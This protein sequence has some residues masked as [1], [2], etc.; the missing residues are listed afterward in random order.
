VD[1]QPANPFVLRAADGRVIPLGAV[2]HIGRHRTCRIHLPDPRVSRH[3]A[4]L[5]FED[6]MLFVR[7]EGSRNGLS[8]NGRRIAANTSVRLYPG[9]VLAIA[10]AAFIVAQAGSEPAPD[11]EAAAGRE[12]AAPTGQLPGPAR[13][14]APTRHHILP[15]AVASE[16]AHRPPAAPPEAPRQPAL[17]PS[18]P[19][20]S[21]PRRVY[22]GIGCGLLALLAVCGV[23]LALAGNLYLRPAS[24]TTA[25]APEAVIATAGPVLARTPTPQAAAQASPTG[26]GAQPTFDAL[27]TEAAAVERQMLAATASQAALLTQQAGAVVVEL[28]G[29]FVLTQTDDGCSFAAWPLTD[30]TLALSLDYGAGSAQGTFSGGGSGSRAG[31]RCGS[32]T[33]D[34]TWS[35]AYQGSFSGSFDPASGGLD[36]AGTINGN[37]AAAWANCRRAGSPIAC[38]AASDSNYAFPVRLTGRFD[39]AAGGASGEMVV[40]NISLA[41]EGVWEAR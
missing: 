12:A 22:L 26:A 33:S 39:Q 25:V 41:T 1:N 9:D 36:L 2:T 15:P 4:S 38:P 40:R 11:T 32:D 20:A 29:T 18:A 3:H 35:Q 31:L 17:A 24:V 8:V 10:D 23:S 19:V 28:R 13:P 6:G 30:G 16:P 37:G 5:A 7:D 14:H 21:R 34:M 27:A